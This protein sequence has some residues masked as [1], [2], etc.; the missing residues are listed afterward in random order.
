[1]VKGEILAE[2]GDANLT[3]DDAIC[4]LIKLWNEE[5]ERRL[6]SPAGLSPRPLRAHAHGKGRGAEGEAVRDVQQ[7]QAHAVPLGVS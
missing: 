5:K 1:M 3:Y 6:T 2:S 7:G 4:R